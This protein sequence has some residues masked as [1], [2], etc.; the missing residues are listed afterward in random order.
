[1]SV[2]DCTVR[3]GVKV[4]DLWTIWEGFGYKSVVDII[5]IILVLNILNRINTILIL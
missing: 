3:V 4:E 1:M 2:T 5:I